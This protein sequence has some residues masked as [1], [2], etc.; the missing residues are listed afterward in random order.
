MIKF[1]K[2]KTMILIPIIIV[3]IGIIYFLYNEFCSTNENEYFV[4]ED[5]ILYGTNEKENLICNESETEGNIQQKKEIVIHIIGEVINEGI[6]NIEEGARIIDAVNTAGGLTEYADTSKVNLAYVLK[7]GQK[8]IIPSIYDI[9]EFEIVSNTSG[10]NI[11][12]ENNG[13]DNVKNGMI[14][15]NTATLEELQSLPGVGESTAQKIINYRKENGE[16][17]N[18]EE[19]KNVSRYW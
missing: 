17:S 16:F 18:I 19:I 9:E 2:N 7:D 1:Q 8:V 10:D 13:N 12:E 6:V 11:I 3:L 5:F 4:S 14:N 15:I